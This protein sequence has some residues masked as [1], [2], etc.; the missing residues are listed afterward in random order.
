[1]WC[2]NGL[3]PPCSQCVR[4]GSVRCDKIPIRINGERGWNCIP[5]ENMDI[6]SKGRKKRQFTW[7]P[8]PPPSST[9][10]GLERE[11]RR[12]LPAC[13]SSP[14]LTSLPNAPP[15]SSSQP[16]LLSRRIRGKHTH[17]FPGISLWARAWLSFS[18]RSGSARVKQLLSPSSSRQGQWEDV[19][20]VTDIRVTHFPRLFPLSPFHN[21]H[22]PFLFHSAFR[23][24][25]ISP[26]R[27]AQ[28]LDFSLLQFPQGLHADGCRACSILSTKQPART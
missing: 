5:G 23:L 26:A 11:T 4:P 10:L 6:S 9:Q 21:P 20:G 19:P 8:S 27:S 24:W 18:I 25:N 1:M 14:R 22:T 28:R 7:F 16:L 15:P 3:L 2:S 13:C 12:A 17:P